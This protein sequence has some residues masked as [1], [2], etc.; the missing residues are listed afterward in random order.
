[1]GLVQKVSDGAVCTITLDHPEKHNA[2]SA[3]L[4]GGAAGGAGMVGGV[5]GPRDRAA[6]RTGRRRSGRR[7]TT[8]GSCLPT[9]ATR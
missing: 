9:V 8:C 1:M 2:L 3:A 7:G 6:G 4:I 5:G